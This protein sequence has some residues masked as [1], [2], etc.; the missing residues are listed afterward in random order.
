MWAALELLTNK[1]QPLKGIEVHEVKATT[2][3]HGGFGEPCHPD[4]RVGYEGKL[5]WLRDVV[6]VTIRSKVIMYLD[7]RWYAGAARLTAL[8]LTHVTVYTTR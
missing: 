5:P 3:I 6:R 1:P 7:Q 4:Q 8:I 2:P